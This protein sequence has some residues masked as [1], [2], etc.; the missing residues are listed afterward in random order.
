M[1]RPS[2]IPQLFAYLEKG[3][4]YSVTGIVEKAISYG[5]MELMYPEL[6]QKEARKKARKLLVSYI[7]RAQIEPQDRDQKP[8]LYQYEAL[9]SRQPAAIQHLIDVYGKDL[10]PEHFA[11]WALDAITQQTFAVQDD[12][13]QKDE[14]AE[15]NAGRILSPPHHDTPE[16]LEIKDIYSSESL[17]SSREQ[18][19]LYE[20]SYIPD[21]VR[22][23]PE[24]DSGWVEKPVQK[25]E[26]RGRFAGQTVPLFTPSSLILALTAALF[27]ALLM[28]FLLRPTGDPV[29][30]AIEEH[31]N[32]GDA[33]GLMTLDRTHS[34][35]RSVYTD[36]ERQE[37]LDQ[38]QNE[39][40]IE[41]QMDRVTYR[42]HPYR[43]EVAQAI[44]RINQNVIEIFEGDV[45]AVLPHLNDP[46]WVVDQGSRYEAVQLG[47]WVKSGDV[48]GYV[49]R[50]GFNALEV[51]GERGEHL[52]IERG[53]LILFRKQEENTNVSLF[54]PQ[55]TGNLLP[56]LELFAR[57]EGKVLD[58]QARNSGQIAGFLPPYKQLG[59]L[60]NDLSML[61]VH[62]EQDILVLRATPHPKIHTDFHMHSLS[63]RR[64]ESEL[65]N[66]FASIAPVPFEIQLGLDER[67]WYTGQNLATLLGDREI[68]VTQKTGSFRFF[69]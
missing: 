10:L 41:A 22:K 1:T 60:F 24:I 66:L 68:I 37:I 17:L 64:K 59:A 50:I 28:T 3:E 38:I 44:S 19:D 42:V 2:K 14:T 47:A 11:P 34:E 39:L 31:V 26:K 56:L 32:M 52:R 63:L 33:G 21:S 53:P 8:M 62:A 9:V 13:L 57:L 45:V 55:D 18:L 61:G 51:V 58:N 4:V 54:Y 27:S 16:P 67:I 7:H 40:G 25:R 65:L 5:A 12:L 46:M 36:Q 30:R 20:E 29:I 6:E 43:E 49:E 48:A 69:R 15:E 35:L 23:D